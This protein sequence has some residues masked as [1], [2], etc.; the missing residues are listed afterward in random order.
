[1]T[2][3]TARPASQG[4]LIWR[5]FRKHTVAMVCLG[6]LI[7]IYVA[8]MLAPWI[9]PYPRDAISLG[10]AYT[11]P[12]QHAADG[13]YHFFGTD[14]LGRDLFTR[15]IYAARVSL[16]T[17]L[18]VVTISTLIGIVIGLVAGYFGGWID[19]LVT[20]FIEFI[21]TFPTFT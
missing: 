18:I 3:P 4:Q 9:A 16:T 10:N 1:M 21:S 14:H 19:N 11:T 13:S 5:R 2:T 15:L 17:A 7:A 6:I 20:R 12:F 8:S